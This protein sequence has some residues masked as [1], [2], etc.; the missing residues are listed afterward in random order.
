M[1]N[2]KLLFGGTERSATFEV[3]LQIGANEFDEVFI[4][5]LDFEDDDLRTNQHHI[6]ISKQTAIKLS[7]EL[8]KQI[9]LID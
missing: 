9:S 5:I 2:T 1:E 3:A 6:C 8:K 4:L 7:K